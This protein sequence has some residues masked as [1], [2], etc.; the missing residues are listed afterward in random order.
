MPNISIN[1]SLGRIAMA[2]TATP[3]LHL[4]QD[5]VTRLWRVAS[6]TPQLTRYQRFIVNLEGFRSNKWVLASIAGIT[7]IV[8]SVLVGY[9]AKTDIARKNPAVALQAAPSTTTSIDFSAVA[10][11]PLQASAIANELPPPLADSSSS[12][13][14]PILPE[15][16]A[17]GIPAAPYAPLALKVRDIPMAAPSENQSTLPNKVKQAAKD[18]SPMA[19]FNEP[20]QPKTVL[21]TPVAAPAQTSLVTAQSKSSPVVIAVTPQSKPQIVVSPKGAASN[22]VNAPDPTPAQA[23]PGVNDSL[24]G[25]AVASQGQILAVPNAESIVVTNPSTRLPMLL[26]IGDRLPDGSVLKSIDK[27]S[28]TAT[29][30]RGETLSLR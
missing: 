14:L 25:R 22:P 6:H 5:E 19:V 7:G 24:T 9:L 21:A 30:S 23:S 27:S 1:L 16:V 15:S 28:S 26:K 29:T 12:I 18:D 20:L 8:L 2:H 13:Q 11:V 10:Y 4:V 3:G 17:L